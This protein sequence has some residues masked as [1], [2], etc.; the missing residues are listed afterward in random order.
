MGLNPPCF[1]QLDNFRALIKKSV[2]LHNFTFAHRIFIFKMSVLYVLFI[3]N[4]D[5]IYQTEGH[6]VRRYTL[7]L[8]FLNY[9][10]TKP[11]IEVRA[12]YVRP[13]YISL[14]LYPSLL[15]ALI[16][17]LRINETS[18]MTCDLW[19]CLS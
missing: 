4:K 10:S 5:L 18:T 12:V 8:I 14:T 11:N 15:M 13:K 6:K 19:C 17:L 9:G 3:L 2:F 7:K 16:R 1:L